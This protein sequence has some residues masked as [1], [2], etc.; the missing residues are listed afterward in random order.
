MLLQNQPDSLLQKMALTN[1]CTSLGTREKTNV[2]MNK[3]CQYTP[4]DDVIFKKT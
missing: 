4:T 2:H 3:W 1:E